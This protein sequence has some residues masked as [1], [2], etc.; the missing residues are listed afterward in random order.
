M[1]IYLRQKAIDQKDISPSPN[2]YININDPSTVAHWTAFLFALR[3][4][5]RKSSVAPKSWSCFNPAKDFTREKAVLT[6]NVVLVYQ[7][8]SKTDQFMANIRVVPLVASSVR[9]LDPVYHYSELIRKND[10]PN[11]YPAFT[12]YDNGRIDCVTHQSFTTYLKLLLRQIGLDPDRWSGHSFRR[13]GASLLYRLGL[14]PLT[15]QACGDW[16]TDTFLK[17]LEVNFERL[18]TAQRTMACFSFS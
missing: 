16:K 4:L 12:Y 1:E 2:Q 15:I 10:V 18:W 6:D 9:A 8:H 11:H 14:D 5:Y 7:N 3:L 13:G 17:Y